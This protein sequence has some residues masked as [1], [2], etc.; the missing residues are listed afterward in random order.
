MSQKRLR[1]AIALDEIEHPLVRKALAVRT[2]DHL[3]VVAA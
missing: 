2:I 1:N 3:F